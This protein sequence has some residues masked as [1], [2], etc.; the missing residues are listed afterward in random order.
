MHILIQLQFAE[1]VFYY[2]VFNF[3]NPLA[4][5]ERLNGI[6]ETSKNYVYRKKAWKIETYR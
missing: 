2:L 3:F 5:E 1:L 4:F 6:Q